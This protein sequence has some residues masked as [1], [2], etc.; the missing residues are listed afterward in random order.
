MASFAVVRKRSSR[1]GIVSLN[2]QHLTKPHKF[3]HYT[4]RTHSRIF[5][6]IFSL[7][8]QLALEIE[9]EFP[10]GNEKRFALMLRASRAPV[11][12]RWIPSANPFTMRL[13]RI[14]QWSGSMKLEEWGKAP[15]S[16]GGGTFITSEL[17]YASS[18]WKVLLGSWARN[19]FDQSWA[20]LRKFCMIKSV[21]LQISFSVINSKYL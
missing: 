2:H 13:I 14:G 1:Y 18:L 11:S 4:K 17:T 5:P 6:I 3:P 15:E 20:S 19:S 21:R 10:T 16:P 8:Q 12:I 9:N 7:P